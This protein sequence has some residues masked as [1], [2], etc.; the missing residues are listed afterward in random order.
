MCPF[1]HSL[2]QSCNLPMI[3]AM[4]I[5]TRKPQSFSLLARKDSLSIY[6]S[7][8]VVALY[9][10]KG[11]TLPPLAL[12]WREMTF[13]ILGLWLN[14]LGLPDLPGSFFGA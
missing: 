13:A 7:S 1:C 4:S 6:S 11:P 2:Q 3:T 12:H 10:L 8:L 14:Y 9:L 5:E